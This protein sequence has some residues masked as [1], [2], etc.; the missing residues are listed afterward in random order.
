MSKRLIL[1]AIVGGLTVSSDLRAQAAA[2]TAQ[3]FQQLQSPTL[4]DRVRAFYE[5]D[6]SPANWQ[7]PSAP[8]VLLAVLKR[9]D[10]LLVAVIRESN[11]KLAAGDKYGEEYSEY[12]GQLQDRC[13]QYCDRE[14]YLSHVL[15]AVASLPELRRS[16][17]D[18]LSNLYTNPRFSAAQRARIN[19]AFVFAASD[20]TSFLTRASGL[21][22][23]GVSIRTG[24]PSPEDLAQ[25][26]RTAV[27]AASDPYANVRLEAVRRLTELKD[28]SDFPLLQRLAAEDTAHSM[29]AG[30]VV[31]PVRDAARSAV[32]GMRKVP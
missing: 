23:I 22:A 20:P 24:L 6:R 7:T 2:S 12:H 16:D 11:G 26:H 17:I 10:S 21:G 30:M 14:Q 5:L 29:K 13:I 27:K 15:D 1:F 18:L 8:A 19:H 9:E 4:G 28:P 3:M 31:Y 25:F 32:L